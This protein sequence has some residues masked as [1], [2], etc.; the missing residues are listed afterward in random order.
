MENNEKRARYCDDLDDVISSIEDSVAMEAAHAIK[1]KADIEVQLYIGSDEFRQFVERL[2][3]KE[4][5]SSIHSLAHHYF[6]TYSFNERE[7]VYQEVLEEAK[8]Y[9][10][11]LLEEKK[12]NIVNEVNEKYK[13]L[14]LPELPV[15]IV[16]KNKI[17]EDE[18]IKLDYENKLK[19]DKERL[20]EL[21]RM[22]NIEEITRPS[23]P[24]VTD[25]TNAPE[26]AQETTKK[27]TFG[28]NKRRVL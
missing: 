4:R 1:Q 9:R 2:K 13:E 28:M 26:R 23:A 21:R 24:V 6:V 17:I 22:K 3:R 5:Y 11:N 15:E 27:I 12:T 25:A 19:Q 16:M 14:I 18:K 7:R 20:E 10:D 8:R